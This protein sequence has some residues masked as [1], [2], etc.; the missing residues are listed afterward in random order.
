MDTL[1]RASQANNPIIFVLSTGVDPMQ[2]VRDYAQR[3]NKEEGRLKIMSLGS[4]QGPNAIKFV[5]EG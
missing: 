2:Q 4:G 5:T 1:F 3:E